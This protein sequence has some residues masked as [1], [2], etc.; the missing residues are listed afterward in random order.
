MN[1]KRLVTL[2]LTVAVLGT[3]FSAC[4][5]K[6]EEMGTLPAGTEVVSSKE[7]EAEE[8]Y[9]SGEWKKYEETI[10]VTFGNAYDVNNNFFSAM[11][12]IGEPYDD[13]RWT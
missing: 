8:K 13:N 12:N 7:S 4:G 10:T 1:R 3:S 5:K 9:K 2:V 6:T 11:A